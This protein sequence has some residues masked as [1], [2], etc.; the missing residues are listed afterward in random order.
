VGNGQSATEAVKASEREAYHACRGAKEDCRRATKEMGAG[1]GEDGWSEHN[2]V[3]DRRTPATEG[4]F[5]T[6]RMLPRD[7]DHLRSMLFPFHLLGTSATSVPKISVSAP[8]QI[9]STSGNT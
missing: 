3:T 4:Y 2:P 8:I 1:E 7:P 9:Q 5:S 6:R